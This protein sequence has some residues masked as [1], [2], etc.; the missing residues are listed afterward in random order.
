M[1][2]D[3]K[4]ALRG[5]FLPQ[6][7]CSRERGWVEMAHGSTGA[8]PG[9]FGADGTLWV[10]VCTGPTELL[11]P[12]RR[13]ASKNRRELRRDEMR[14]AAGLLRVR[15]IRESAVTTKEVIRTNS[16]NIS[17]LG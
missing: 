11:K 5:Q 14:P 16:L 9:G 3:H 8:L 13:R 1:K 6:L 10:L 7:A 15:A 4:V 12:D 17:M 2:L